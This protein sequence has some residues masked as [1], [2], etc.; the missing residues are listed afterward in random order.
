MTDLE[1]AIRAQQLHKRFGS[2][3]ALNGLDLEVPRGTVFG[4]LGPNGAGKTTAVRILATLTRPD[5]GTATV[6]GHDVV[7]DARRVRQCIGLTGQQTAVDDVLSARQNLIMFGRLFRLDRHA[8]ARRADELLA[9]FGLADVAGKQPK[10]FSG[11]MRRRLDLAASMILAPQ[12]LFLDEPTTGLDPAGRG[13]VWQAIRQLAERGTTVLLTT[14]YLDEADKLCDRISVIDHGRNVVEDTPDGLKRRMGNE[15]LVIVVAEAADL[16][17][18]TEVVAK[19]AGDAVPTVN[20]QALAV[21]TPV[22][23]GVQALVDV[24]AEL[25]LRGITVADLGVRRPTLD[26][27]FLQLTG[28]TPTPEETAE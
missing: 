7:L 23:D 3:R 8:A 20:Q 9:A 25:R 14:H 2:T 24:A 18:V 22:R 19:V 13:E 15:H 26:E 1:L 12:V 16:Q 28:S 27:A 10:G 17:A 6:A 4:L 5:G 11:G 21:G